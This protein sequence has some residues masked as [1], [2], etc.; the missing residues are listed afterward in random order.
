MKRL[1]LLTIA[2]VVLTL[3]PVFAADVS[4][5][6]TAQVPGRGGNTME[7]TFNFKADG[8]KLTGS[9]SNQFGDREISDGKVTGDDVSFIINIEFGGNQMTMVYKGKASGNEIKFTRE[10]KGGD[11]PGPRT[12]EF[13]AKK[14]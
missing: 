4:G 9:M 1:L 6:W 5:Q 14:K 3:P 2:L 13:V 10:I 7:T 8:E 12:Q 11:F